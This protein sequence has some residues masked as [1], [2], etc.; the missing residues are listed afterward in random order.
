MYY[1]QL[2]V[3]KIQSSICMSLYQKLLYEN[4]H[5]KKHMKNSRRI[6]I[7]IEFR[8]DGWARMILSIMGSRIRKESV[9]NA[10]RCA[11]NKS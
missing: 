4:E 2:N 7:E 10:K 9:L 1:V 8:T 5:G 6:S 3:R 11:L